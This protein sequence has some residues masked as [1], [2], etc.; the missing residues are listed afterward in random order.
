M[1]FKAKISRYVPYKLEKSW[2][3]I[4]LQTG[5]LVKREGQKYRLEKF[6]HKTWALKRCAQLNERTK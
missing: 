1:K 2:G 6:A 5:E 3:I 4:D